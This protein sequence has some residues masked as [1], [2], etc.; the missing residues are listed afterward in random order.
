MNLEE[1][2]MRLNACDEAVEYAEGKTL[3]QA[4]LACERGDWMLWLAQ[5]LRVP[6]QGALGLATC[7]VARQVWHLMTDDRSK[8]AVEA[9]EKWCRGE[10]T[11][12]EAR[13]AAAAANALATALATEAAASATAWNALAWA[14]S[15]WAAAAA[16]AWADAS[17]TAL[18]ANAAATAWAAA[19]ATAGADARIA[20]LKSSAEIVRREI[21][22][23]LILELAKKRGYE[24]KIK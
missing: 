24:G 10:A 1:L 19:N 8:K 5:K 2:L 15:A 7:A 17:A 16:L 4:W 21:P 23:E 6:E 11:D 22:L 12:E 14:A 3:A 20:S 9:K 13:E 18:A